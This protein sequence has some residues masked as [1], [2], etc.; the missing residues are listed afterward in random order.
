M[1]F[2]QKLRSCFAL[3]THRRSQCEQVKPL[4]SARDKDKPVHPNTDSTIQQNQED[5]DVDPYAALSE[6]AAPEPVE[7]LT[8]AEL[9]RRPSLEQGYANPRGDVYGN[10]SEIAA[11]EPVERLTEE[12]MARHPSLEDRLSGISQH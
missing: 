1:A 12:E 6:I 2:L 3:L 10:L 8:A 11:P 4:R 9:A 5:S 7:R